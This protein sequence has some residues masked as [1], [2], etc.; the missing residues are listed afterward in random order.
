MLSNSGLY[1][2]HFGYCDYLGPIYILRRLFILNFF[3]K[4][5][6]DLLASSDLSSVG[7]ISDISSVFKV[8]AVS[9]GS[10]LHVCNPLSS[11]ESRIYF[12]VQISKLLACC[13]HAV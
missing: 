7:Y 10:A 1:F 9:F 8:F 2:G 3:F 11:L 4:Q 5:M 6:I 12:R 13:W